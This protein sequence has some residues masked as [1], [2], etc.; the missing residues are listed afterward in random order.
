MNWIHIPNLQVLF[1]CVFILTAIVF[2]SILYFGSLLGHR[3]AKINNI[4]TTLQ[5]K[6]PNWSNEYLDSEIKKRV[7]FYYIPLFIFGYLGFLA[8]ISIVV[9]S[10]LIS[11]D[12][13]YATNE[14]DGKY[15]EDSLFEEISIISDSFDNVKSMPIDEIQNK[16]DILTVLLSRAEVRINYQRKEISSLQINLAS[17]ELKALEAKKIAENLKK[18]SRD[19]IEAI[20]YI[21]SEDAQKT[22][23]Q[24][25]VYGAGISFPIGIL[26]SIFAAFFITRFSGKINK[27]RGRTHT[28]MDYY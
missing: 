7:P 13:V 20:K 22:N 19:E 6:F 1:I 25:L 8:I 12:S 27:L 14:A 28:S 4:K 10:V 18:I 3:E 24:Y 23:F 2:L 5:E 9:S 21:I 17:E 16:V 15:I 11:T 26:T